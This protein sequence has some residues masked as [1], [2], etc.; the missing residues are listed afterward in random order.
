MKPRGEGEGE[1]KEHF[2]TKV[3]LCRD[4]LASGAPLRFRIRG[5]SML[6]A[7]W[8]GESVAVR[9]VQFSDVRPGDLAVFVRNRHLVVHRVVRRSV[10]IRGAEVVTRGDA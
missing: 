6:P 5:T 7:L 9:P 8:P 4:L 10:G 3:E 1:P 2:S